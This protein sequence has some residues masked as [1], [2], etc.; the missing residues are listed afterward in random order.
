MVRVADAQTWRW[1]AGPSS[2]RCPKLWIAFYPGCNK[3]WN[4]KQVVVYEYTRFFY[5][6]FGNRYFRFEVPLAHFACQKGTRPNRR[7]ADP[8]GNYHGSACQRR[9][10][11]LC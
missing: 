7:G 3:R 5:G 10:P 9:F 6:R 4:P 11:S 1:V 2:K 8:E